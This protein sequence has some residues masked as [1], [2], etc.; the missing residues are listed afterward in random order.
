MENMRGNFFYSILRIYPHT[1]AGALA[2]LPSPRQDKPRP[3]V[4]GMAWHGLVWCACA[5]VCDRL[6]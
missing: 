2:R 1:H 6:I 5:L 3:G 4:H